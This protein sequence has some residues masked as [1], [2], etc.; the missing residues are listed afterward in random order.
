MIPQGTW[1]RRNART[2]FAACFLIGLLAG[3]SWTA[4]VGFE[5]N[6]N[7]LE[8]SLQAAVDEAIPPDYLGWTHTP[9]PGWSIDNSNMAPDR[10]VTEWQGWSFTTLD[11]WTRAATQE[12][13]GFQLAE[14][15]FAVADPDEWDDKNK[16]SSS[17]NYN[18]TLLSPPVEIAAGTATFLY[19][20]SHYR[21]ENNQ[22]AEVRVSVNGGPDQVLLRYDS[23]VSSDNGGSDARNREVVLNVPV[24]S[25]D[26]T[27]VFKWA[28]FD[29]GNNWYWAIDNLRLTEAPPK[30]P[31]DPPDLPDVKDWPTFMHD[32]LRSGVTPASLDPAQMNRLWTYTQSPPP[33]PAWPG[34]AKMDAWASIFDLKSMRNYDPVYHVTVLDN[35]LYFGSSTEDCVQCL[36]TRTGER[37]W[38]FFTG[39]PVRLPPTL[40]DDKAYFGSDDGNAYCVE[41]TTGS[42]VWQV[43]ARPNDRRVPSD[44]KM[45]SLWPVR[46]GVLVEDGKAYFAASLL[47]WET[48][49]LYSVDAATGSGSGAGLFSVSRNGSSTM[50]GAL[51][52]SASKLYVPQG[53]RAPIVFNR[54]NGSYVGSMDGGGG[55]F[56][57]LTTDNKF[58]HGHGNKSGWL[59]ES[60]TNSRDILVTIQKG[61]LMIVSGNI[62]YVQKDSSLYAHDRV[63]R[64]TIWSVTCESRCGLIMAGGLLLLGGNDEVAAFDAT[65]GDRLWAEQVDGRAYGLAVVGDVLY[66]STD[67]GKIYAMGNESRVQ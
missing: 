10:G 24:P 44:G 28:L 42:L 66:V 34:P 14:G 46:T 58:I 47:P 57:L 56:C 22:K 26:S 16:P 63:T 60:D 4:E 67:T 48:S 64:R 15:V 35:S 29:A 7:G 40:Y 65:N 52:A 20:H 11:F 25:A 19:F 54:A 59:R 36:D 3:E 53:R 6:F 23:N 50:E 51:L 37:K 41:A 21:Q 33:R 1:K 17:G 43:Q 62:A 38:V 9:P 2:L 45:I 8:G 55:V 18:S 61:N 32:H 30:P 13:E 31:E 27:L 39:G 12:R 5:E 49:Y